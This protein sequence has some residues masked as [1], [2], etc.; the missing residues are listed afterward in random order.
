MNQ[1]QELTDVCKRLCEDGG[2]DR[3]EMEKRGCEHQKPGD[4]VERMTRSRMQTIGWG[5]TRTS[6][7]ARI[8]RYYRCTKP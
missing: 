7:A 3:K 6:E 1:T 8:E 4:Y 2:C 5:Q